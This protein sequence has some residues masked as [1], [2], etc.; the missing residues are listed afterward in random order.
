MITLLSG[1]NS[2]EIER[3]LTK[4][5]TDFDGVPEKIDGSVLELKNLPDLL[6]GATIFADKRMVIIKNLS[7][8][9][10]LWTD[11]GDWL[12]RISD[13]I[14]VILV[15]SKPDKRTKT[16][17]ELQKAGVIKD[18]SAWT[19]RDALA[20]ENWVVIIAR[21]LNFELDK[22]MAQQIVGRVGVDQWQLWHAL[23]KLSVMDKITPEI[24]EGLI[25]INPSENIFYLFEAALK[26]DSRTIQQIIHTLEL[27]ED[28]YRLFG[29][30]SGQAFQLAA[31]AVTDLS[32]VG[33][34]KDIGAHPY[35]L[36]KLIPFA[37]KFGRSGSKKLI[38]AFAK[39]D[40]DM[41]LSVADPW[42]LIERALM[43]VVY[44]QKTT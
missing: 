27:T 23:E 9:K 40:D 6:S 34:A 26:G 22:K 13:D 14:D 37:A 39:A 38:A 25:D 4:R 31:L 8:N 21:E 20:A 15:E 18:Y 43:K 7:E 12:P 42:L 17:K 28:P 24:I 29:L 33:V 35:A 41:K 16:Y 5:M 10:S 36:S 1:E 44:I 30:L 11:F 32:S 19:E 3:E 2:F